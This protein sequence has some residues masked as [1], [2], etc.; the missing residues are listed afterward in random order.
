[1][2]TNLNTPIAD[3]FSPNANTIAILALIPKT[4]RH[5]VFRHPAFGIDQGIVRMFQMIEEMFGQRFGEPC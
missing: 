5:V 3:Q 1:M 4:P 2:M